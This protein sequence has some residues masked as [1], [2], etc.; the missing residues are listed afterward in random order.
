MKLCVRLAIVGLFMLAIAAAPAA[1]PA[2][3]AKNLAFLEK[4]VGDWR[5]EYEVD[6]QKTEGEFHCKWAS[7]KYQIGVDP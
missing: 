6:G 3:T 2:P 4:L 1:D 5:T 7:G